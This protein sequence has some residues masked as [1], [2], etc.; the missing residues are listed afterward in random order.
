MQMPGGPRPGGDGLL[1]RDQQRPGLREHPRQGRIGD[2]RPV[3]GQSGG[4]RVQAAPGHVPLG[5]QQ[6]DERIGE[7]ALADRLR[8]PRRHHRGRDRAPA[9]APV[10]PA[11]VHH[12]P[13]GH[14]PVD[15]L[16]DVIA[17]ALERRAAPL[18]AVTAV[19]EVPDHLDP[20]QVRVIPAGVTRPAPP[21][22]RV[23]ILACPGLV[24]GP[25]AGLRPRLLRG[26]AEHHPLQHGQRGLHLLQLGITARQLLTQPGVLRPQALVLRAQPSSKLL[27]SLVRLQRP[28]QRIP[29]RRVSIHL[30]KHPSHSRHKAQQTRSDAPHHASRPACQTRADLAG[31]C[32][33]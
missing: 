33:P 20:R 4:Q 29:Q 14:L 15:L 31:I 27:P 6:R 13:D 30:R 7:Q 24:T 18:A 1:Q 2:V 9:G 3:P 5:E 11:P 32:I 10:P 21:P 26:P 8:R 19:L 28:G 16:D 17:E 22:W 23:S 25:A 12:Q